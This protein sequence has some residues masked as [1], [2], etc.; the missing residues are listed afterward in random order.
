M[1]EKEIK[2]INDFC[3]NKISKAGSFLTF[4]KLKGI[5]IHPA[6]L[7]YISAE[8]DFQIYRD[9]QVLLQKSSFDYS[10]TEIS[11]YFK[12]IALEIKKSRR[13]T[14]NE[15]SDLITKAV[16]FNFNFTTKPNETLLDFIF[17][18]SDSLSP[19]EMAMILDYPYYYNYLRQILSSYMGK[20]QLLTLEK[21][22][23]EFLLNK[24]D[25][26]L[27]SMKVNELIDNALETMA[28]F[29][30]IGA[31]L[32][33]QIPPQAIELYLKEKNLNDHLSRL[34][35]AL[36]QSPKI[37]YEIDEIKKIIY[38][39]VP[40]EE[41]KTAASESELTSIEDESLKETKTV[42]VSEDLKP[43]INTNVKE[44]LLPDSPTISETEEIELDDFEIT[45]P[46]ANETINLSDEIKIEEDTETFPLNVEELPESSQEK[47]IDEITSH[48]KSDKDIL[49][50]LSNREI[51][52]IIGSIFNEDKED[53]ATTIETISECKTY[54][55]ATEILKSLYTTYNVNPY[56]R[57]AIL[58]TNAVAKYF[59]I[60]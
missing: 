4:E 38:T 17:K 14:E 48:K 41:Q 34:Q 42:D 43:G 19:E 24:I 11:K 13:I 52:K 40:T 47:S 60:A 5:E 36:A 27:F 31:V 3:L 12:M 51:E 53:F 55:K 16:T 21:K 22:E 50:F 54:E 29:F 37:K 46:N 58:L 59:T 20:K 23:L 44:N 49:S 30:N 39:V 25:S 1:F 2:F 28:D 45:N 8:I 26:E 18:E 9:R 32:R 56:S 10:G 35:N 57:D 7:K 6:I 15:I 33:S